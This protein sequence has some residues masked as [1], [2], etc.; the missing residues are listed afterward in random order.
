MEFRL[1]KSEDKGVTACR[2]LVVSRHGAVP[3]GVITAVDA[4]WSN[5]DPAEDANLVL[6]ANRYGTSDDITMNEYLASDLLDDRFLGGS[7]PAA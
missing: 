4:W 2:L 6:L 1:L 3:E 5:R 7:E